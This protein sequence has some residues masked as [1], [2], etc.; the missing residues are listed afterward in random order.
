MSSTALGG[1]S[2]AEIGH[3]LRARTL[4]CAQVVDD[5][6]SSIDRTQPI[7]NAF[8]YVDAATAR[9]EAKRLDRDLAAGRDR[10]PLHGVPFAVKDL[11]AVGGAPMR[12]GSS[13]YRRR[14]RRDATVVA[15][16]RRAGG[17][18][19]GL[20]RL[21]EIALGPTGLNPH[22]GGARNPRAFGHIPGGSS[23]GSAVA[24]AAGLVPL[25]LGTDT[26]GSVRIPAALCGV[27]G[28]KPTYGLL[29]TTGVMPLA[30][31]LDHVGL[32][33]RS[34]DDI[35]LA[36]RA[37]GALPGAER[38]R[39]AGQRLGILARACLDLEAPVESA[40]ERCLAI[41]RDEGARLAEVRIEGAGSVVE[42]SSTIL[43]YEAYRSH[44]ARFRAD[45]SAFGS[46]I[47]QRLADGRAIRASTYRSALTAMERLRREAETTFADVAFIVC[48]T[49][50]VEALPIAEAGDPKRR[51]LLPRNTRLFNVLGSPAV[52]IPA[53]TAGLP[54]GFQV[55][56]GRGHDA[57][58]LA[59]ARS[60]EA[61]FR[62]SVGGSVP[63]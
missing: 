41:L 39:L 53:P 52:S 61:A 10:G 42:M 50:P 28:F 32:L 29:S 63:A 6:L 54:V 22:D 17:V 55:A 8:A 46:D 9:A 15:A 37:V 26:G 35:E 11:I 4:T 24:V 18:N 56:A 2:V 12:A 7:V 62:R 27:A 60:I 57:R 36:L 43:F 5:A 44:E 33:A 20:T 3:G 25:A 14:P 45:P 34:I 38:S 13:V 19:V 1:L 40:F 30:P 58:L 23:S 48:P 47:R 31:T 16:I 49:V 51:A 59:S 21:H